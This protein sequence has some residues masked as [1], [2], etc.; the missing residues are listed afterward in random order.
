MVPGFVG[1]LIKSIIANGDRVSSYVLLL[2][3]VV[4][5][6]YVVYALAYGRLPTPGEHKRLQKLFD[7]L[8]TR[9]DAADATLQTA[10]DELADARILHASS[11]VRIEFLEAETKRKDLDLVELR[12]RLARLETELDLRRAA[13]WRLSQSSEGTNR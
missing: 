3:L 6:T 8:Q 11:L 4:G 5:L 1:D 2:L 9:C 12:A 13:E 10:R 7:A